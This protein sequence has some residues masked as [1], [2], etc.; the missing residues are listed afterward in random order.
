MKLKYT[1]AMITAAMD[2]SLEVANKGNY[3]I[4]SV[5]GLTQP[6]TCPNV[7]AEVLSPR[8]SWNNDEGYY[9]TAQKLADSFKNNFKAFEEY[10]SKEIM[11]G[12]PLV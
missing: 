3:H 6:R 4:H 12:G 7:P 9:K 2:G 10:A 8:K 11:D 5:F 1:R